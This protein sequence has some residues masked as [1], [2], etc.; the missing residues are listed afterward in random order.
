H[1]HAP[2]G[3][4]ATAKPATRQAIEPGRSG[5]AWRSCSGSRYTCG[6][7]THAGSDDQRCRAVRRYIPAYFPPSHVQPLKQL[8]PLLCSVVHH[9]VWQVLIENA[10]FFRERLPVFLGCKHEVTESKRTTVH[11]SP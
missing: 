10:H 8:G 2:P 5:G 11:L 4:S 6:E 9:C 1:T 7:A 3:Q